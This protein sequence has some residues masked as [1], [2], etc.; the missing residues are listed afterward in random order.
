LVAARIEEALAEPI[1]LDAAVISL[2]AGIGITLCRDPKHDPNILIVEAETAMRRA[3]ERGPGHHELFADEM[4]AQLQARIKGEDSLRRAMSGGEFWVAY[5]PKVSLL[6]EGT[7]GVEALL[8]WDHPDR[9]LVPPLEFVPLAEET[10]LIVPIGAWVLEQAC[11]AAKSW[12]ESLPGRRPV[13]VSVNL[14]G[15]QFEIGLATAIGRII[16]DAGID[17]ASLCVE[18]TESNV[19]RDAESAITTLRELKALG[20]KIS[21]DDFGTGYSSLAYLRQFPVDTLKI[22]RAFVAGL[23]E[24]PDASAIIRTVVA[25]AG[26]L[27][28]DTV[29]EGIEDADQLRT[30]RRLGCDYGQGYLFARPLPVAETGVLL[31]GDRSFPALAEPPGL[32]LLRAV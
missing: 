7:V 10:G 11:L 24:R 14:S 6:T 25:L 4:R 15:R 31:R 21:I 29:A 13:V 18:V 2:T 12:R 1:G 30:L 26:S 8:R 3:K 32:R 27:G 20:L 16:A 23:G 28:I 22:D 5:Q 17:P 9:G 19:M